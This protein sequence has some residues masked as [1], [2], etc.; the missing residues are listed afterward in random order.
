[1]VAAGVY[2]VARMFPIFQASDSAMTT[3]AYVGGFTAIFA[4]SMGLVMTDIKRVLA[5][6]TVSQLGYMMLALGVGGYVAAIFHL[7]THAFFKALLFLGSGSVNHASG[8][9][10]MRLMGGLRKFMPITYATF[11]IG[12]LSLAGVFP[13]AGFWSKDEILG[14]VWDD[15]KLLFIVAMAVV[16]MTAFYS[17]RAVFLTF[18][19]EYKGGEAGEH[20]ASAAQATSHDAHAARPHE[21]PMVMALPLLLLAIPALLAG[22]PN[23]PIDG[24]DRLAH[25]LEGALPLESEEA[26]HHPEFSWPIALGSTALALGGIALAFVIYE[27]KAISAQSLQRAFGPLHTL[28]ARKYYFDELYEGI[29]VRQ[30]LYRYGTAAAQWFDTNVVDGVV[31]GAANL[32]RRSSD[33]LRWV[34]SGSVQAYGTIGFGGLVL[35]SVLMLLLVER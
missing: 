23:L 19:G 8:T 15:D 22:I 21:S 30:G 28:V 13:F 24:W 35:A 11:F 7:F 1:M 32:T 33:A 17:F 2:L 20:G 3:V 18:H 6:S 34:Q 26:L 9:F 12:S 31:N 10:D 29:G 14:S 4:A 16:F 27:A 25:L 5:Y